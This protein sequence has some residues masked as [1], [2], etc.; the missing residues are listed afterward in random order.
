MII[1]HCL[2]FSGGMK[3]DMTPSS[4]NQKNWLPSTEYSDRCL[5]V[6]RGLATLRIF[7]IGCVGPTRFSKLGSGVV[8]QLE[9][10]SITST[11][12]SRLYRT[13]QG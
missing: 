1:S 12:Y 9:I 10:L 8:D 2:G 13:P 6:R 7:R 11:T 3:A 5:R 4:E